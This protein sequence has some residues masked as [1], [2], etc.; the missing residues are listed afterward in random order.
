[1]V[2]EDDFLTTIVCNFKDIVQ[3]PVEGSA[4]ISVPSPRANAGDVLIA[5]SKVQALVGGSTVFED[6]LPGPAVVVVDW[7]RTTSTFRIVVPESGTAS[8]SSLLSKPS[9]SPLVPNTPVVP[10]SGVTEDVRGV[11]GQVQSYAN[12]VSAIKTAVEGIHTDVGSL[13]KAVDES[14]RAAAE[15]AKQARESADKAK[16]VVDS[17][18]APSVDLGDINSRL[19]RLEKAPGK[20]S[21]PDL[22]KSMYPAGSRK[23]A[24]PT[25]W[26]ADQDWKADSNWNFVFKN[27]DLVPFVLINPRSG[28]GDRV[29]SD[30]VSL[31]VRL[32][33]Q[34]VPALGYVRTVTDLSTRSMRPTEDI[35]A[36]VKR[37]IEFYGRDKI[38]GVFFDEAFNGWDEKFESQKAVYQE[39]YRWAKAEFGD[40]FLVVMNPGSP[41]TVYMLDCADVIMCFEQGP[42]R[43]LQSLSGLNPDWYRKINPGRLWVVVHDI[44][45]EDQARRVLSALEKL[46]VANVY[47]TTDSFNG[48]IGGENVN[49]NPWDNLPAEWLQK[50]QTDWM[51]RVSG[52]QSSGDGQVIKIV[53]SVEEAAALP[54]G[55]LYAVVERPA[56]TLV[57]T[58]GGSANAES[59]NV[60]VAGAGVGDHVIVGINTKGVADMTITPPEGFTQLVDG[61]WAGTQR[62]W[63]FAGVLKSPADP[64]VFTASAPAEFGWGAA[65]VRGASDVTAGVFKSRA[66]QPVDEGTVVTAKAVD[67]SAGDLVLGFAFDRSSMVEEADQVTVSAGW[68]KV[69]F[70]KQ[71]GNYQTVLIA[72]GGSGDLVVTYP[73]RQTLNGGGVQVVCRA[74]G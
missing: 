48:V 1:M 53:R 50:L 66:D 44:V 8:L 57:G 14:A 28:A 4:W 16:T 23:L 38:S 68:E 56:V 21:K 43:F 35:K 61:Y 17:F 45:S 60:T 58:A 40:D 5:R 31:L 9:D 25:Y 74:G 12:D 26:W 59:V 55:T 39:L 18:T 42:E 46:N 3:R 47:L 20:V 54:V 13:K 7:G 71:S 72:K 65:A 33:S 52:G 6:V 22:I 70:T 64:L 19:D 62:S 51:R 41:T 67:S 37:Y 63:L 69:H 29:E 27:L 73:N 11:L 36:E 30:F 49:N 24:I 15:S 10:D 2:C 32:S 34:D